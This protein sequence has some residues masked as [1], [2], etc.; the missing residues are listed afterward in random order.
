MNEKRRYL[1]VAVDMMDIHGRLLLSSHIKIHNISVG[2]LAMSIDKRLEIG[3][4]YTLRLESKT[5]N[6]TVRGT[7]VWSNLSEIHRER[8]D[9]VPIYTAGMQFMNVDNDKTREME[10]FI[11]DNML[12]Y[13][14]MEIF[15]PHSGGVRI[16]VRFHIHAPDQAIVD[17]FETYKVKN[18]SLSG[19]LIES[20]HALKADDI[21]PMEIFFTEQ[22]IITFLGRIMN[23]QPIRSKDRL[24][25]E[26]G[27]EFI[28]IT[29]PDKMKLN[30]FIDSLKPAR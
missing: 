19:M 22:T 10:E 5:K 30:E 12:G 8:E 25:Y 16:H 7:I 9:V 14:K 28:N 4:N 2:G 23:C 21:I 6:L 17:Y 24:Y 13:Q 18:I 1:R 27:I 29:D 20:E 11:R 3:R 15:K 26:I